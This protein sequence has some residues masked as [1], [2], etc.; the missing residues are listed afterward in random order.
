MTGNSTKEK[1]W[2]KGRERDIQVYLAK[3]YLHGEQDASP[4]NG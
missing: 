1:A 3:T 4:V 2:A